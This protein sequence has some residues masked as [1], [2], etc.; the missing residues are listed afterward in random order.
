MELH[1]SEQA[2]TTRC[3]GTTEDT[4]MTIIAQLASP[5]L[6]RFIASLLQ[7]RE[8][9]QTDLRHPSAS[10]AAFGGP[11][12][13]MIH[14]QFG[15]TSGLSFS[16]SGGPATPRARTPE[17]GAETTHEREMKEEPGFDRQRHHIHKGWRERQA[18]ASCSNSALSALSTCLLLQLLPIVSCCIRWTRCWSRARARSTFATFPRSGSSIS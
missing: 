4:A 18:V 15:K 5:A 14:H 10:L 9:L 13:S 7:V 8:L 16:S 3:K 12:E 6:C 17:M 2:Q 1:S 11:S